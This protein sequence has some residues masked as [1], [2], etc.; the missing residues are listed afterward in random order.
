MTFLIAI[1]SRGS[2][3]SHYT[4]LVIDESAKTVGWIVGE[5]DAHPMQSPKSQS[6]QEL[7]SVG[8]QGQGLVSAGPGPRRGL[9]RDVLT[10]RITLPYKHLT[11]QASKFHNPLTFCDRIC[12]L[13]LRYISFLCRLT[14]VVLCKFTCT[15]S[16]L[17]PLEYRLPPTAQEQSDLCAPYHFS[18]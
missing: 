7:D 16:C 14:F 11:I 1:A 10:T 9:P 17:I 18:E 13:V 6:P 12:N 3:E 15:I 4:G 5:R 2:G 8:S